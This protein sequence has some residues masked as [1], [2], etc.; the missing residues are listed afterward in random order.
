[1]QNIAISGLTTLPS[2]SY[3]GYMILQNPETGKMLHYNLNPRS[4][5]LRPP[6][7][8]WTIVPDPVTGQNM[9]DSKVEF[10]RK[11]EFSNDNGILFSD[12]G[13]IDLKANTMVL[14]DHAIPSN[15]P[16]TVEDCWV[17]WDDR[18]FLWLPREYRGTHGVAQIAIRGS[19]VAFGL[20]SGQVSILQFD[21]SA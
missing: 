5:T 11:L 6:Y 10:L 16:L 19:A 8:A 4:P 20:R 21:L 15:S 17:R 12:E 1:M 2:A 13:I 18:D 9:R 3:H 14:S 7:E